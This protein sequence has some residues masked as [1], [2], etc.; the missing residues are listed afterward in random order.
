MNLPTAGS[1]TL[2]AVSNCNS[3]QTSP[4]SLPPSSASS[5]ITVSSNS[6]FRNASSAMTTSSSSSSS[7]TG[8]SSHP[9]ILV[10]RHSTRTFFPHDMT[11]PIPSNAHPSSAAAHFGG[12]GGFPHHHNH[13]S[14]HHSH[15]HNPP[16]H[17]TT[18]SVFDNHKFEFPLSGSS[19]TSL[20][21]DAPIPQLPPKTSKYHR[22]KSD[23]DL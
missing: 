19:E 18:P 4:I 6:T 12:G 14:H 11:L 17:S 23:T 2:A 22:K 7:T 5:A 3:A 10:R 15:G 1:P 20:A 13:H 16:A 9:P 8:G 21:P